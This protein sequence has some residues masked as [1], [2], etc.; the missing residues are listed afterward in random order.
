MHFLYSLLTALG[1]LLLSPY[2]LVKGL[3]QGKYLHNLGERLGRVPDPVRA[4]AG[5][6]PTLWLHAVSVG[7]VLAAVPLARRL[8]ESFPE[9]PLVV[10]TTTVTGQR[11]ARERMSFADAVFYFPLDWAWCVRRV[12]RAVRPAAVIVVETEI[13][14]NFLRVARH[15]RVPVIF[16]NGRLSERSYARLRRFRGW[17]S[18]FLREVLGNAERFLMQSEGDARRLVELG[19]REERVEVTGNVKYDMQPPESGPLVTWLEE[20]IERQERW[21]VVV[22]GSVL[23]EEEGEV[24]AAFDLVQRKWRRALLVLAPR[25]LEQFDAAARNVAQDGWNVVRR[26]RLQPG[27]A[28]D[29]SADVLLLDT[30]GELA[31]VYWLADVTF[32][33]GSLVHAGG[34]NILEPAWFGK[35]PVFGP[36][37][38]NFRDIAT[39]FLE[40]LAGVQVWD[41]AQL[42][43]TWV[44]LVANEE[45][46]DRMGRAARELVERNRGATERSLG[47]IAEVLQGRG[48]RG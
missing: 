18:G 47:R 15:A 37:M 32:V 9:Y 48:G 45:R 39:D 31:G 2:F 46:R 12:L 17:T 35:A 13:W 36:S 7:E 5:R 22:A 21:P 33:G 28:L 42:G 20:Q 44:E 29:E 27:E 38:E 30:L 11:V 1:L 41:G 16:V 8:Q 10:S 40:A 19:A 43:E 6:G 24:L 14:P 23:A 26:S 4:A 25:R 34:H 3:R